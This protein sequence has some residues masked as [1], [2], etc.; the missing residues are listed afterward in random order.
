MPPEDGS[1]ALPGTITT[2]QYS[3]L[4]VPTAD[5]RSLLAP[6]DRVKIID[7]KGKGHL[8]G[9]KSPVERVYACCGCCGICFCDFAG[10]HIGVFA[11]TDA[12]VGYYSILGATGANK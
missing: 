5:V 7:K 12:F 4:A 6:G 9:L 1:I 3:P 11:D 8:F 10:D 2:K